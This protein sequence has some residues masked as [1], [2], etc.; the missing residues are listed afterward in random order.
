MTL[1]TKIKYARTY[2][3]DNLNADER[4]KN[5]ELTSVGLRGCD[6]LPNTNAQQ[7]SKHNDEYN[8]IGDASS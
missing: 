8:L 4:L 6:E 7:A 1:R 5:G 3:V 2:I